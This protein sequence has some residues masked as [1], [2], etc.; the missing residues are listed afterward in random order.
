MEAFIFMVTFDKQKQ[1]EAHK[2]LHRTQKNEDE[3]EEIKKGCGKFISN[4]KGI[5]PKYCGRTNISGET[6]CLCES[7]KLI[8]D[9]L[10]SKND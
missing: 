7:C 8:N 1:E 10:D 5:N 9:V 2:E 6:N 3:K 4:N